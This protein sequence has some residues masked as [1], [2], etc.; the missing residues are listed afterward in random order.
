MKAMQL[1][2]FEEVGGWTRAKAETVQ[3]ILVYAALK[4]QQKPLLNYPPIAST[5]AKVLQPNAR[6]K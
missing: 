6:C 1:Q 5:S 3:R 4:Y 2:E